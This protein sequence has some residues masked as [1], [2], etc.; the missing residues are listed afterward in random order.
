M[1]TVFDLFEHVDLPTLGSADTVRQRPMLFV[2]RDS[3]V[4]M[5]TYENVIR[6]VRMLGYKTSRIRPPSESRHLREPH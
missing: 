2:I 5:K 3:D 1:K 4:D 6:D